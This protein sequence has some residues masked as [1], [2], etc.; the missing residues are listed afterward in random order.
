VTAAPWTWRRVGLVALAAVGGSLLVVIVASYW[1]EPN[2]NLAY[3][4]AGQ[5]LAAGLP[6]YVSGEAAFAPYAYHYPPPLAQALAPLTLV[7]PTLAYLVAYRALE[8][9]V[10]WDLAGRRMLPM[11]ALIAVLPVA[12]ELRFENVHLFVALGIVVGLRRWPWLFAVGAVVKLSPGLGVV[13]LLLRRRW[14]DAVV[15][16]VIGLVIAGV[17]GVLDADLWRAW[18]DSVLGRADVVGNSLLP[19]PYIARAFAG[20]ALAAVGGAIGRRRGEL[21]LVAG[22]TVANPGLATNGLAVLAAVLPIWLAGPAGV[23]DRAEPQGP[24]LTPAW[25]GRSPAL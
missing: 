8:L 11:L 3:W 21:L 14:R 15:A 6:V 16:I 19:V 13:Y 5:R 1:S 4:L 23:G 12:V 18:L 7:V 24:R 20:L 17:S 2:D 10:T 22:I 9:L 25:L